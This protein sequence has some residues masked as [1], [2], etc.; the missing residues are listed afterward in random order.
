M[1][2]GW[3]RNHTKLLILYIRVK[4]RTQSSEAENIIWIK[5]YLDDGYCG[6]RN[7]SLHKFDANSVR[8]SWLGW[9]RTLM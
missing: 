2:T 9:G 7:I 4:P 6:T 5:C 1:V 3:N 8:V